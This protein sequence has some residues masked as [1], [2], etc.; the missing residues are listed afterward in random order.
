[1]VCDSQGTLDEGSQW[2]CGTPSATIRARKSSDALRKPRALEGLRETDIS[3]RE[4]GGS[5][6]RLECR[7]KNE[8]ATWSE[9]WETPATR[10][11]STP[12]PSPTITTRCRCRF[13]ILTSLRR[14]MPF[15]FSRMTYILRSKAY[16][17]FVLVLHAWCSTYYEVLRRVLKQLPMYIL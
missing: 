5:C 14:E 4:V 8:L 13:T 1:M 11:F 12:K 16:L 10:P 3:R 7:R 15:N 9:P 17:A 2:S 6:A